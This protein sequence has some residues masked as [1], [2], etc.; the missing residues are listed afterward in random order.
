MAAKS[1]KLQADCSNTTVRQLPMEAD[2]K[3][4]VAQSRRLSSQEQIAHLMRS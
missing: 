3:V 2:A 4:S 1:I